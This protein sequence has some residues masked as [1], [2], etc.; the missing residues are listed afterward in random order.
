MHPCQ[1][2]LIKLSFVSKTFLL[3]NHMKIFIFRGIFNFHKYLRKN[4]LCTFIKSS[5]IDFTVKTP[6]VV[7]FQTKVS[8]LSVKR[9]SINRR[10]K[11]DHASHRYRI[12][13]LQKLTFKGSAPRKTSCTETF[14]VAQCCIMMDIVVVVA[15]LLTTYL[16]RTLSLPHYRF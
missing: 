2:L 9:I 14:F 16:P 1:F 3:R 5:Y 10:H 13:A 11:Y 8:E 7:S 15:Y 6:L 12:K 4:I